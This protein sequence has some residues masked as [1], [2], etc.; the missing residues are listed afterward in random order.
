MAC[1]ETNAKYADKSGILVIGAGELGSAVIEGL[2]HYSQH[3]VDRPSISVMVSP[4]SDLEN[5]SLSDAKRSFLRH[6]TDDLG[7]RILPFDLH[8]S[9]TNELSSALRPFH[10]II[11]CS[12]FGGPVGL[13][14]KI[15]ECTLAGSV[16]YFIPW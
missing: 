6:L 10:T 5:Q 13:Q 15:A 14:K 16:P 7:V 9:S 12:G 8:Q 2:T 1:N 11:S 3:A 4:S